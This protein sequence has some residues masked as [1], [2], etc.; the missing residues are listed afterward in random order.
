MKT[1]KYRQ[2]IF[3]RATGKFIDWHYWGIGIE[4]GGEPA[5][6]GFLSFKDGV[7]DPKQSQ[8]YVGLNDKLGNDIYEGDRTAEGEVVVFEDGI[9]GTT[10]EGNRQGVSRLSKTRCK[11]I[12][13]VGNITENK[14][15]DPTHK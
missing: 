10:Y 13:I 1:I 3:D 8:Q 2:P 6:V 14:S 11:L 9:F 12:E 5:N 15:Y 7:T 4:Q